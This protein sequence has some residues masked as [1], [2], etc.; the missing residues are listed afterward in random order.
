MLDSLLGRGRIANDVVALLMNTPG[1]EL[2]TR[3]IA[4]RVGADAHPVQ[5][6]LERLLA[7][8]LLQSRRLGNLRLWSVRSD[9]A[10]APAV[11]AIVRRTSGVA[12]RLRQ[13][14]ASMPEAQA[15]FLFG[16]YASGNDVLGSDIDLF[17][18]GAVPWGE[19]SKELRSLEE[20]LGRELNPV[21][22]SAEEIARPTPNK[23][24]F[25]RN[26]LAKD[27]IWLVGDDDEFER[28]RY[29]V[30]AK[31]VRGTARAPRSGGRS[32]RSLAAAAGGAKRRSRAP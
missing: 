23:A 26:V 12:E 2:H 11:R 14:L 8:G 18:V 32:S 30:G 29:S 10:L 3:E 16:S 27:K 5:R 7:A 25:L 24:A 9:S 21:V 13:R 22:W 20:E 19:L 6:A 28:I 17:I 4:R 31:V 1:Q 15:A